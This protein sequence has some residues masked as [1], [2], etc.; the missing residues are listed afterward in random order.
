[1]RE[2]EYFHG[3]RPAVAAIAYQSNG[4]VVPFAV[5]KIDRVLE[6]GG[7]LHSGVTKT[8][9]SNCSI[10]SA[11]SLVF[12]QSD[13]VKQRRDPV[14]ARMSPRC[15]GPNAMFDATVPRNRKAV[16]MT[17]PTRRRSSRGVIPR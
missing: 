13:R 5:Q 2:T 9:P 10:L 17:M 12:R 11:Q 15:R 8:K 1:M 4:S 3:G 16:C 6:R 14:R 7:R